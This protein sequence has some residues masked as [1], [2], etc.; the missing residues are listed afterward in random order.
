M[1]KRERVI[2][3]KIGRRQP[4]N[5]YGRLEISFNYYDRRDLAAKLTECI[6]N[7]RS[8]LDHYLRKSKALAES[9][10]TLTYYGGDEYR[11]SFTAHW[12]DN[13]DE[14]DR[15]YGLS[16]DLHLNPESM[17]LAAK[18]S[19]VLAE[20]VGNDFSYHKSATPHQFVAALRKLGAIPMKYADLG[21]FGGED[22]EDVDFDLDKAIPLP[23][24]EAVAA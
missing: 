24:A 13:A 6:K 22:V 14:K 7:G 3:F 9:A 2:G 23:A 11:N 18:L 16:V 8:D 1:S 15:W 21:N 10:K 5:D 20:V 19:K 17:K 12:Q 4:I